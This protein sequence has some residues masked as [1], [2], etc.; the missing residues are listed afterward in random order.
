MF[1]FGC[2]A[3]FFN[4]HICIISLSIVLG[5][6]VI[7]IMMFVAGVRITFVI[8]YFFIECLNLN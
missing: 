2:G 4:K 6:M 7:L 1:G 8:M 3:E 5:E